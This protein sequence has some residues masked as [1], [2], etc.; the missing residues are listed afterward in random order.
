MPSETYSSSNPGSA[1][2]ELLDLLRQDDR[3]FSSNGELLRNAVYEAAMKMDTSLIRLLLKGA[4][5]RRLFFKEVSDVLVFD[6]VG[7]G[8][9]INNRQFLPDSYTRF[10]NK[11]GLA[12]TNER[13]ISSNEDVVLLFPYK[14]CILEGGQTKEE[15]KKDEIFYNKSLA[16]DEVDRLLSP[17]VLIN[18]SRYSINGI[19]SVAGFKDSDNIIIKGN[20][21]LALSSLLKRYE[22]KIKCIYADPP[23]N[24]ENDSFN[25]NDSFS[26]S[27]WLTF[28]KNRLEI[29]KMLL[30]EDGS[31]W[32]SIDER[33][34]H[35]LKVLCDELFGRENFVIQISIQRGGTTGHKA[36]NPT[37]VQVCDLVIVYAKNKS[38]WKY[39]PVYC[40]RDYD[41]AY[42]QY[43]VNFE[44]NYE[45]WKFSPLSEVLTSKKMTIDSA[46]QHFPERIIR[47]AQP[48]Y[49]AIGQETKDLIDISSRDPSKV[50][51]QQREGYSDIYLYKGNRILFYK[52]KMKIIDGK[53]VT[54]ELVTNMWTDMKYQGIA[55]EGGVVFK[56]GKKP[57]AQIKRIFDM[58]TKPGDLILDPFMGSGTAVAVAHKMGLRYIGIEQIDY[59]K[60]DSITRLQ[61]VI[62]GDRTG[63]SK[64]TNWQGGGTFVYC[65][66]MKLNQNFA[67]K[68]AN[69]SSDLKLQSILDEMISSAF[70]STRVDPKDI[71]ANTS[72][73][74]ELSTENKKRLLFELL[75]LNL[76]YVNYSDIDDKD[77]AIS[78]D[79]RAFNKSF[80]GG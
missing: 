57:E 1:W 43:I 2:E 71:Q 19:E 5:T 41:K 17:K 56:K 14:D 78:D 77:I 13:P 44:D 46:L 51:R 4:T 54:A 16:P 65:E 75:D 74:T 12:D 48:E 72:S 45:D 64:I 9:V 35:Y 73:F 80:Y 30:S 59:E 31:I 39:Q 50:Y 68:I 63:I 27:T 15:Q 55:K 53:V 52:D 7:F 49:L 67:D 28:M 62:R 38:K 10:K 22:G 69:E 34:V 25:Y 36:I 11:I 6:K 60:N 76:L 24:S 40:Q 20:N 47:L 8:W 79:E 37:P 21:L 23:Y 61:N 29:M 70:I 18:A 32:I 66:L 3:F 33:E 58:S 26:H 42:N